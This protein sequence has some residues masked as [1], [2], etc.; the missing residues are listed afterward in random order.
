MY[1]GRNAEK[2]AESDGVG[3]MA[4]NVYKSNTVEDLLI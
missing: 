4:R 1:H 2:K 3:L